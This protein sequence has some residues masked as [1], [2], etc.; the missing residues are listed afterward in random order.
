MNPAPKENSVPSNGTRSS[1][2]EDGRATRDV[3]KNAG[4]INGVVE[5]TLWHVTG[6]WQQRESREP[7]SEFDH[8]HEGYQG[9]TSNT[10]P[11]YRSRGVWSRRGY[12]NN[13]PP[14]FNSRDR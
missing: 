6:E 12:R 10:R 3:L 14:R 7:D 8:S 5:K 11:I 9:S 4:P 1:G 2:P 13:P